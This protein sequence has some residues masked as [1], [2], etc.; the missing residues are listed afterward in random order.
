MSPVYILAFL[1]CTALTTAGLWI[2]YRGIAAFGSVFHK[3]YFYYLT[4]FYAF[5][6]Y[7]IWAQV[8]LYALFP[9][10]PAWG[11]WPEGIAHLLSVLSAP[12]LFISWF[13]LLKLGYAL[14]GRSPRRKE[15][16]GYLGLLGVAIGLVWVWF[17]LVT[18][19]EG[20]SFRQFRLTEIGMVQAGE[21]L[22]LLL[23]I[24]IS[25]SEAKKYNPPAKTLV[26][27]FLLLMLLGW[28][29]RAASLPLLFA[30]P[31][32]PAPALL[33]YFLS[34]FFPLIYL[35]RHATMLFQPLESTAP[36]VEKNSL[37]FEKYGI[38]PREQ[39]VVLKICEGKS[40]QQIADELFISLQTVKD[41]THRIYTKL[42]IHSRIK[43]IKMVNG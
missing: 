28:V 30:G 36:A 3:R 13:M 35:F 23:F 2:S 11:G 31:W 4:A 26:G 37:L 12:F 24:S 20:L 6:F 42:G 43:L 18:A 38:T 29:V 16:S 39:D 21:L 27:R 32:F 8:V 7:G 22:H 5:G 17:W 9:D 33:L 40:N 25:F 15:V 34:N 41:H 14:A 1:F 19:P 10:Q